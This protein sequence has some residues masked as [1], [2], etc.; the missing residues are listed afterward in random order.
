MQAGQEGRNCRFLNVSNIFK[1]YFGNETS[2]RYMHKV[3][4]SIMKVIHV[5]NRK[6]RREGRRAS[7]DHRL[8]YAL[9]RLNLFNIVINHTICI[10]LL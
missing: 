5:Y 1:M 10:I 9:F 6:F 3:F 4:F 2:S 7:N 8:F